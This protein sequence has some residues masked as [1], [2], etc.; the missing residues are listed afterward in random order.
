MKIVITG[1]Y[2]AQNLGDEMILKGLLQ[3]LRNI[4]P[5]A[6]L[7]VLSG[8]PE[9]TAREYHVDSAEKFPAGFRSLWRAV[10]GK[11]TKTKDEVKSCDYFILGG[12]GL[13]GG[14]KKRADIIWGIQAMMAYFYGKPVIMYGQSIGP[15]RGWFEKWIVKKLFSKAKLI[16]VRDSQSK[17][18]LISLGIKKKIYIYPDL[19]FRF[20][21]EKGGIE[22]KNKILVILRQMEEITDKFKKE[23]AGFANWLINERKW[24]VTFI[25]FQKGSESDEF[26]HEEVTEMIIDKP[27]ME[28]IN[29]HDIEQIMREYESSAMV[30]GMR[31]HSLISAIK[32]STPFI[33]INYA[34]K[35]EGLLS[36]GGLESYM[37]DVDDVN[38][39]R[40]M[41][42]F[43]RI[44][45]EKN[46]ITDK[47]NKYNSETETKQKEMENLLRE[48]LV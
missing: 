3:T 47:L 6:E 32:T 10:F 38:M 40:L 16:I 34:P 22:R 8:N 48:I 4:M 20:N 24:N 44:M 46:E 29:E 14:L 17:D 39:A 9:E 1:N 30:L 19:A 23:I 41:E 43:S 37:I 13:F 25:T 7:T 42:E 11:N 26:L 33:A 18:R 27:Y 36:G 35:V 2:G 45:S 31:L 5:F 28:I 15:L 12:G 21:M